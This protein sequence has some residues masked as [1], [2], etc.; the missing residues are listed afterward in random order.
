MF[1]TVRA[2]TRTSPG[3]DI[4]VEELPDTVLDADDRKEKKRKKLK[5]MFNS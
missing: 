2:I 1:K 3:E 4:E 5:E